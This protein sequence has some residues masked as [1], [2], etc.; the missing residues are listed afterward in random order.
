MDTERQSALSYLAIIGAVLLLR[1]GLAMFPVDHPQAHQSLIQWTEILLLAPIGYAL[2]RLAPRAGFP[3]LW[4]EG[5]GVVGRFI[6]PLALGVVFAGLTVVESL[7]H[8]WPNFHVPFP[9]SIFVYGSASVLYEVK[10]HLVPVVLIVWI[11]YDLGLGEKWGEK[12]FWIVAILLSLYEP[13]HQMPGMVRMHMV[14][15]TPWI[16]ASFAKI[17][18]TDLVT[19]YLFR[20]SG[21]FALVGLRFSTYMLWHVA[22]PLVYFSA[23]AGAHL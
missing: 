11:V 19:L 17:F 3:D 10:Y 22:W 12:A 8:H 16:A 5:V 13:L 15:G 2:L 18:V 6:V 4:D 23:G 21:F 9:Q 7:V 14:S 1:T 20:R